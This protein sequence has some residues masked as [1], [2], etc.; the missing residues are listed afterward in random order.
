MLSVWA[1]PIMTFQPS[2]FGQGFKKNNQL[3][4]ASPHST[5]AFTASLHVSYLFTS[6]FHT[7]KKNYLPSVVFKKINPE[8]FFLYQFRKYLN[9]SN[10]IEGNPLFPLEILT[11]N[12][13]LFIND[14]CQ[15]EHGSFPSRQILV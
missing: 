14:F 8:F 4:H 15:V 9:I 10:H 1:T 12:H 3:E 7:E 6:S 13:P 2:I 5:P 11:L